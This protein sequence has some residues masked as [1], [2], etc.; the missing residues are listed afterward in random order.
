MIPDGG[1]EPE[2]NNTGGAVFASELPI[3]FD[4]LY[5][6]G[7]DG[8][9]TKL[10]TLPF[11][12]V[13]IESIES[14]VLPLFGAGSSGDRTMR[15]TLRQSRVFGVLLLDSF[16]PSVVGYEFFEVDPFTQDVCTAP[17]FIGFSPVM[18]GCAVGVT[19][20]QTKILG[21]DETF[22][23]IDNQAVNSFTQVDGSATTFTD[24]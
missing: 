13:L 10:S 12:Q 16:T 7:G 17:A 15:V 6:E 24:V 19:E 14:V 21:T 11:Q 1:W 18:S 5:T 3:P 2:S 8:T 9:I 23:N 20:E 22:V 4:G